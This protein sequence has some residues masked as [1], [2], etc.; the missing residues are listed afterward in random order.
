VLVG[1]DDDKPAVGDSTKCSMG[2]KPGAPQHPEAAKNPTAVQTMASIAMSGASRAQAV[3][4]MEVMG[5]LKVCGVGT[6]PRGQSDSTAAK[7]HS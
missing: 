7:S 1:G 6:D 5:K 2:Q 3:L 4:C